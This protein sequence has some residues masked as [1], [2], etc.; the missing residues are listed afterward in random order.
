MY[1]PVDD[2]VTVVKQTSLLEKDVS[3]GDGCKVKERGKVYEGRVLEI[4][5]RAMK[6]DTVVR[7]AT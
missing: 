7:P 4:G 5:K 1:F 3:K 2:T 6:N